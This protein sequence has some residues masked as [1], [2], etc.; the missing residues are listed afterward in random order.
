MKKVLTGLLV[1]TLLPQAALAQEAP[2]GK[3]RPDQVTFRALY[4]ELVE[5]NTTLSSG[6]CTLAAQKL[7]KH[8]RGAGFAAADVSVFFT[9]EK[10]KEGGLTAI[11]RGT[12]STAKPMLLMGHLDVVE[13]KREDWTRDP[14]KLVEEKGLRPRLVHPRP[15]QQQR[16]RPHLCPKSFIHHQ[17]QFGIPADAKRWCIPQPRCFRLERARNLAVATFGTTCAGAD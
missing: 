10:P 2:M 9:P 5:T 16:S 8:L 4:Q 12:S 17:P 15:Q 14:F 7:E 3:L 6:S 1:L 13:A 11:L